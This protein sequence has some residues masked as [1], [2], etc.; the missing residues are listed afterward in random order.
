VI[1]IRYE[2]VS[3]IGFKI[4][5][6]DMKRIFGL[7]SAGGE[8]RHFFNSF[9]LLSLLALVPA[10]STSP[11]VKPI[12]DIAT[13]TK[14]AA[15]GNAAFVALYREQRD[16]LNLIR[17]MRGSITTP[18]SGCGTTETSAECIIEAEED[19]LE[20]RAKEIR[21]GTRRVPGGIALPAQPDLSQRMRE[22]AERADREVPPQVCL[23]HREAAGR[24]AE[25]RTSAVAEAA[26]RPA[27]PVTETQ[28][29]DALV[30]YAD[31]LHD[32]TKASDREAFNAASDKLTAAA[33][34]VATT[35]GGFAGPAGLAAAGLVG[36]AVKLGTFILGQSLEAARLR[37]LR[38][39]LLDA[40]VPFRTLARAGGLI[41][42]ARREL[43]F[44][45]SSITLNL[46]KSGTLPRRVDRVQAFLVGQQAA[47]AIDGLRGPD[48]LEVA[49]QQIKAHDDL[50]VAVANGAD[51]GEAGL[52]ALTKFVALAA[53]LKKAAEAAAP[54]AASSASAS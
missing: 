48:P 12:G 22:A 6:K 26:A 31:A 4:R 5:G 32:V 52:E 13:G 38:Q 47:T 28:I 14:D 8:A 41:G 20:T 9:A 18:T 11:Y 16:R 7:G 51:Q 33:S 19:A 45:A 17:V 29:F 25:V 3:N 15:A 46:A 44:E 27:V 54:R 39:G 49:R 23:N 34:T 1:H 53:E 40:C 2:N 42:A 30:K 21:Q 36:P 24:F 35:V 10:C 43:L 50:V 37:A